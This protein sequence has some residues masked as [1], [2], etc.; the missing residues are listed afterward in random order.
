M[1]ESDWPPG[2]RT[3]SFQ[4]IG[5]LGVG[6]DGRTLYWDGKRVEVKKRIS[7]TWWQVIIALVAALGSFVSAGVAVLEYVRGG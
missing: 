2:I 4:D 5:R 6:D 7:L 1:A 3:V